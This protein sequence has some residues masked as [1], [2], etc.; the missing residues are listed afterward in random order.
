MSTVRTVLRHHGIEATEDEL[1]AATEEALRWVLS[2]PGATAVPAAEAALLDAGGLPEQRGAYAASARDSA[3]AVTALAATSLTVGEAAALLGVTEGRVRHKVGRGDLY[4]L[5]SGRRRLPRW[6]FTDDAALPGLPTVVRA[7][8]A[9][10]HPL[11]VLAFMTTPQGELELAGEAVT[12]VAWL[13]AGGD[14]APVARLAA[15]ALA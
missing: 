10:E 14:P 12:P 4:A 8:P 1:A 13:R 6:Q 15:A 5:P 11:G 3:A 2:V 9:G 7:L